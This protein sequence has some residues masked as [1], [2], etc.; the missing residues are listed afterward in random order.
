MSLVH[1]LAILE[2]IEIFSLSL[3]ACVFLVTNILEVL[4]IFL[5]DCLESLLRK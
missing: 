4:F 5:V 3:R 1:I 2:N